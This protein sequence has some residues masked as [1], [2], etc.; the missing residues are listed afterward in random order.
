MSAPPKTALILSLP[1]GRDMAALVPVVN[2]V[3]SILLAS[4]VC[5]DRFKF[6]LIAN[7]EKRAAHVRFLV[8]CHASVNQ[9]DPPRARDAERAP[10][11]RMS[12]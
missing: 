9:K 10:F 7:A 6:K 3:P 8:G 1:S 4:N 12:P 5:E 2:E 11:S